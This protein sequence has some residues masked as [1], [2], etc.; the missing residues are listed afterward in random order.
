VGGNFT[1]TG[2][3]TTTSAGRSVEVTAS[4]GATQAGASAAATTINFTGSVND[5][6]LGVNLDN[7][8]QGGGA[9]VTFSGGLV[10]SSGANTGFNAIN[11]G[12]VQVCNTQGC[13]G[14][15]VTNTLSTSTGTA[16]NVN[17]TTI[18][19][20]GLKFLSIN[21]GTSGSPVNGI[22]LNTTGSSGGLTV[23][24][25]GASARNGTGGTIQNTTGSGVVLTST[26]SVSLTHM[27]ING[28]GDQGV[29]GSAVNGFVSN[30][31]S[32]SGNGNATKEG[33]MRFG[34]ETDPNN[35][36]LTGGSIGSATE[37]RIDNTMISGSFERG[38]SI[39]NNSGTLTMLN[40]HGTT[41]QNSTNGSGMLLELRDNAIASADLQ[42]STFSG[43]KAVGF[44][45]T[46]TDSSNLTVNAMGAGGHTNSFTNNTDGINIGSSGS[47]HVT[48]EIS[49]NTISGNTGTGTTVS[50]FLSSTSSSDLSAK[51]LSN[52]VTVPVTSLGDGIMALASGV[53]A[54]AHFKIDSNTVVLNHTNVAEG[55]WVSTPDGGSSPVFTAIVTN[56]NVT[57]NNNLGN[58]GQNAISV[59]STKGGS[60][61]FKIENN[62]TANATIDGI[63]LFRSGTS[64]VSLERGVDSLATPAA[65]VLADNNPNSQAAAGGLDTEVAGAVTVVNN[66]TITL[67]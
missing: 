59:Q 63:F 15:T 46:G 37:T 11:G 30:W 61:V 18:G 51:I 8:D 60:A 35:T 41:I 38:V 36:G 58:G 33:A 44:Q 54:P 16:L 28:T 29:S 22:V 56:N 2:S 45:G 32:F 39:F 34:F 13:S 55:I 62:T 14:A 47:A 3:I 50:N 17:A 24:G 9:T 49:N 67:P 48:T 23:T 57:M 19:S 66:G 53:N 5:S 52:S 20:Q 26:Q 25:D 42:N 31:N 27:N 21:A 4:G 6:G 43:N 65:T 10:V 40:V 12:T 1:Y 7:N 64:S